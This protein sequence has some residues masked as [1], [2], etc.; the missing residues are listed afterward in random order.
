MNITKEK[1]DGVLTIKVEGRLDTATAPEL[2][3]V[4]DEALPGKDSL[5]LDLAKLDYVSS[6]GLRV[7]L[8]AHKKMM[9]KN[10]MKIVN[11]SEAVLEI[12]DITGFSDILDIG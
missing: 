7:I 3:E 2:S 8:G 5:I 9:K 11:S 1:I 6:A 12:F 4:F 10:G